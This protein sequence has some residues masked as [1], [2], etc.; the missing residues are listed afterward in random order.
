MEI[1]VKTINLETTK[2]ACL[3]VGVTNKRKL[4]ESAQQIDTLSNG[5][6]SK[7]LRRGDITGAKVIHSCYMMLLDWQLSVYYS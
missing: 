1:S 3:V 5:F 2:S 6:I 7:L 4:T